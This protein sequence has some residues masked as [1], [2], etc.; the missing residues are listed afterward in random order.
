MGEGPKENLTA[1]TVQVH[2]PACRREHSYAAPVY[3]CACGAPVAPPLTQGAPPQPI[4]HRTWS[5]AWVEVRCTACGRQDHWPQPEL[6]CGCGTVLRIPV[7]PVRTEAAPPPSP[8]PAHIPLPRTATPPRPAF[9]PEPVRTAHDAVTAAAH[10]LTWLGFRDVTATDLPGRR[11]ATGIDVRGRGLIATV[12]PPGALPAALRDIECLWLHGLSSS[13]RAVYF[14]PAGF[15]DDALA[16]AEE[17]HIPL[18]V[19]D[20]AGTP[21]PGNGPADELV[22][23]GA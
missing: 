7:E 18:F 23:T 17:L 13:V 9:H 6:G 4:L 21:R 20:P 12:D 11:P 14:A 10:Y 1:T 19:L 16:R 8:A 5:E 22:G 3:P 15:T 2:C